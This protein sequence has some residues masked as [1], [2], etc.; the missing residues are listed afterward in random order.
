MDYVSI[1]REVLRVLRGRRSQ[2][3]FSRRL[4]YRT[5]VAYAWE[6]G[7][8][9]PTASELFRAAEVVGVDVRSAVADF[10]Y[11]RLPGELA[12][13]EP[14][15]PGFPAALLR[16]LRGP[17]TMGRLGER[18]GL[19][20]SAVSRILAARSQPRVPQFFQL[21]D[22]A[23]RRLLY[24]LAGL[25]DLEAIPSARV[26]WRRLER[27]RRLTLEDPLFESVPR[28]LELDEWADEGGA[29]GGLEAGPAGQ[30]AIA[31]RLGVAPA[32]VARVLGE[33]EDAGLI[34]REGGRWRVDRERS[35]ETTRLD[36]RRGVVLRSHWAE[37]AAARMRDSDDGHFAYL[38]FTADEPTLAALRDLQR[39]YFRAFRSLAASA[40]RN[41][42]VAVA[43]M[44][45][46]TID[47][48]DGPRAPSSQLDSAR[49]GPQRDRARTS[50]GNGNG[51]GNG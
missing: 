30:E 14:S 10:F 5:N 22:V 24:L 19:S 11:R 45:M 23:T 36:P 31:R 9:F 38:V 50:L 39:D 41:T 35:V 49:G 8:R 40:P 28:V 47:H 44:H 1:A 21:V 51:N 26:E 46:F 34:R 37:T 4:G 48:P 17:V 3:A 33:L 20:A 15:D 13:L 16:A 29:A 6:S 2:T 12:E 27:L 25:V 43:N 18:A 32:E 7:R 42:R